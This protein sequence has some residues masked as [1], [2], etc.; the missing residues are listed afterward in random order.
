MAVDIQQAKLTI[1]HS[2]RGYRTTVSLEEELKAIK[3]INLVFAKL[4]KTNKDIH[5]HEIVNIIK[6]MSNRL[7]VG[8]I[9]L[10]LY[11]MTDIKY[12]ST[13]DYIIDCIPTGD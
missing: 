7:D 11:E 8:K 2:Y 12:H 1:A 6:T 9:R 5:A 10:L 4:D 13:I 3:R